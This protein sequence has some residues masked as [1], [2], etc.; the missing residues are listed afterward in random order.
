M[1]AQVTGSLMESLQDHKLYPRTV[2]FSKERGNL[3]IIGNYSD[4]IRRNR[5]VIYWLARE[6][7]YV[8]VMIMKDC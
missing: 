6:S 1:L 4:A 7:V 2:T 8:I 5:I 3:W